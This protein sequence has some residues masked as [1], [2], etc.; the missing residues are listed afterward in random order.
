MKLNTEAVELLNV[1]LD[2]AS[3]KQ[4]LQKDVQEN[5]TTEQHGLLSVRDTVKEVRGPNPVCKIR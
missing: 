5:Q 1:F 2:T 3:Q 4:P